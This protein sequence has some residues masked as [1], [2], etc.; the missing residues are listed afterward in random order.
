MTTGFRSRRS[1]G[2]SR[3]AR[4]GHETTA[5]DKAGQFVIGRRRCICARATRHDPYRDTEACRRH[6]TLR[7]PGVHSRPARHTGRRHRATGQAIGGAPGQA[8]ALGGASGEEV[9][10]ARLVSTTPSLAGR[11]RARCSGGPWRGRRPIAWRIASG[12]R[13]FDGRSRSFRAGAIFRIRPILPRGDEGG[14]LLSGRLL[15]DRAVVS[16]SCLCGLAAGPILERR[17]DRERTRQAVRLLMGEG[18]SSRCRFGKATMAMVGT[19]RPRF[20]I[21]LERDERTGRCAIHAG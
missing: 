1:D 8:G 19:R 14:R 3:F 7:R 12:L 21:V 15:S 18:A 2:T 17:T 4:R 9:W 16:G 10:R 13:V 5:L 11:T 20:A 6:R